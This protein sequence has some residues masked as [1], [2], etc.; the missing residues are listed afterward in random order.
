MLMKNSSK[1]QEIHSTVDSEF[2]KA[3]HAL[4]K[5]GEDLKKHII[6]HR[7]SGLGAILNNVA[8]EGGFLVTV[9]GTG[10]GWVSC[11]TFGG[12]GVIT[13]KNPR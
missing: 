5:A 8:S 6:K 3:R 12:D 13:V 11:C 2:Q 1:L 7:N 9:A 10:V 4:D